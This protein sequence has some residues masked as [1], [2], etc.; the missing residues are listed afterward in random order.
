MGKFLRGLVLGLAALF[1][2]APSGGLP[3]D[4]N[5]KNK[6]AGCGTKEDM[7]LLLAGQR[8][9]RCPECGRLVRK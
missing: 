3:Q 1:G 2:F 7:Q 9:A 6:C 8:Q 4:L 5:P